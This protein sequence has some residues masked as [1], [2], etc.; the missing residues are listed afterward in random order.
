MKIS[1]VSFSSPAQRRLDA[2]SVQMK[3][4]GEHVQKVKRNTPGCLTQGETK[5]LKRKKQKLAIHDKGVGIVKSHP[6]E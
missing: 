4:L 3:E 2:A 5:M 6:V 1:M